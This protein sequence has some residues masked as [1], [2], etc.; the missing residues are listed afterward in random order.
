MRDI[1]EL[2]RVEELGQAFESGGNKREELLQQ[3]QHV[4][5]AKCDA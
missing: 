3:V 2:K 5:N 4:F 1:N